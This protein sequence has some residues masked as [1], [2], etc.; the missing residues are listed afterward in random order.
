MASNRK[1]I[2]PA[3][4]LLRDRRGISSVEFAL[5]CAVFFLMVFGVIDFARAMWEW[6]AAAKA[7]HWG[8]RYAVVNDM[9][10]I[11]LASFNGTLEGVD[12]GSS[13]DPSV[14][15]TKLGTDT[16]TC[17][18]SGCNGSGD[19]TTSFDDI[20]FGLI[21]AQMQKIYDR[22]EEANVEVEYRH[23][24]LGFAGDPTS[25]DLHPLV[26]VRLRNL[27][28][29]FITPGLSGIFTLTMPNFAA[30]MTGEDLTSF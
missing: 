24:G 13:V 14:V 15:V 17:N 20:S 23:V 4:R 18:S 21:V 3:R 8:V 26:T 28:F 30:S 5:V 12:A 10:S 2:G 16:F 29:D 22:I 27:D 1:A 7:T 11:K 6:N 9:V 19:T 25:P